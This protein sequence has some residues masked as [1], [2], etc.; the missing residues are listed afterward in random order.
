MPICSS[1]CE[2]SFKNRIFAP[3]YLASLLFSLLFLACSL[4]SHSTWCILT[5]T[6]I[7]AHMNSFGL[8]GSDFFLSFAPIVLF[9]RQSITLTLLSNLYYCHGAVTKKQTIML[10]LCGFAMVDALLKLAD[11]YDLCV[12]RLIW[13]GWRLVNLF[14][15]NSIG[16]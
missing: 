4:F 12:Y 5:H 1:S 2:I 10:S 15:R 8:R 13:K 11:L 7:C 3:F 9:P 6:P 16:L 14:D